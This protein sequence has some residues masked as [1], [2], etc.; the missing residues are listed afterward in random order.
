MNYGSGKSNSYKG[1]GR[2]NYR[3]GKNNYRGGKGNHRNPKSSSGGQGGH[4]GRSYQPVELSRPHVKIN[5]KSLPEHIFKRHAVIDDSNQ[6]QHQKNDHSQNYWPTTDV[7]LWNDPTTNT[8]K[9]FT[10]SHDGHWRLYNT[11]NGFAKDIEHPMGGKVTRLMVES[12]F[13]FCCF[14]ATAEKVPG[15]TVGMIFAWNLSHPGDAP[16]EFHMNEGDFAPYAHAFG[17]STFVTSGDRCFSGGQDGVIRIW[18]FDASLNS[19]KGGFRLMETCCGHAREVTGLVMASNGMLWSCSTDRTIRLWDSNS[20]WEC[21]HLISEK[22]LGTTMS[23]P[24]ANDSNSSGIGHSDAIT[25]LMSFDGPQGS[26]ILSCSL[27]HNIKIWNSSNGECV[28]TTSHGVGITCMALSSDSKGH[29][30]LL[31]GS[32]DGRVII[33]SLSQTQNVAPMAL[34]CCIDNRF[35]ESH[36]KGPIRSIKTGPGSTFYTAGE[37]GKLMIWQISGDLNL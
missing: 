23:A 15:A 4:G 35:N 34:L 28:S 13:L 27:D 25:G 14:E 6:K 1:G 10:G 18:K 31:C 36:G 12:N 3:G 33:R 37:D 21:K 2:N 26:F 8:L 11:A 16:V 5:G 7:A 19:G 20:K 29:Q 32:D 17:V 24:S 9:F 22:T 30:L